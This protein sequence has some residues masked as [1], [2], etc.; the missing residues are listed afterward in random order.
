MLFFSSWIYY[1]LCKMY[2]SRI[3][4]FLHLFIFIIH[5]ICWILTCAR[6]LRCNSKQAE[7]Y[8]CLQRAITQREG[9]RKSKQ[10]ALSSWREPPSRTGQGWIEDTGDCPVGSGDV[11]AK[12]FIKC[13]GPGSSV[14]QSGE[15]R[16]E[17]GESPEERSEGTRPEGRC[18]SRAGRL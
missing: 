1:L 12:T 2:A 7:T 15:A 14:V 18:Q 3:L 16:Q 11:C 6:H 9:G 4:Y 5:T 8:F 17:G 13:W 10:A